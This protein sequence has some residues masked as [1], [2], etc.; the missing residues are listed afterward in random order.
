M[1]VCSEMTH[2]A[3]SC[4]QNFENE[5]RFLFG[6][7]VVVQAN[8]DVTNCSSNLGPVHTGRDAR[9]DANEDMNTLLQPEGKSKDL[10]NAVTKQLTARL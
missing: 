5:N 9:C 1:V 8:F 6:C 3:P 4:V 10:S 2:L 7:R